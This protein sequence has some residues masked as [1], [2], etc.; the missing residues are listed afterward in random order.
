MHDLLF[1]TT[2]RNFEYGSILE[3]GNI[4]DS[5]SFTYSDWLPVFPHHN[6]VFN[7]DIEFL[8]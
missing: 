1:G 6:K 8:S 2:G 4:S 5:G 3:I 7:E